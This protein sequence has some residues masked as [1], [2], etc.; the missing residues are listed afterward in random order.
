M[1]QATELQTDFQALAN[2]IGLPIRIKYY[3]LTFSGADY[4]STGYLTQ[5]GNNVWVSGVVQPMGGKNSSE[6]YKLLE[7]GR[8][9]LNDSK[10]YVNGSVS[11]IPVSGIVK[12]GLGSPTPVEYQVLDAGVQGWRLGNTIV[13]QKAYIRILNGG[14]FIGEI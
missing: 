4:D 13:Y 6:D 1:V 9:L 2:D 12:V 11:L 5:S 3:S 10:L 14:S 7:Q 8:I